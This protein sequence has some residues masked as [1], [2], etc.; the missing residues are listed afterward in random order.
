MGILKGI[1]PLSG[2]SGAAPLM[3]SAL[4]I[5]QSDTVIYKDPEA[6]VYGFGIVRFGLW[7]L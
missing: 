1:M 2:D 3:L 5:H 7:M 6:I 4:P